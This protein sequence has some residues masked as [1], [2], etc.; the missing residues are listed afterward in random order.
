MSPNLSSRPDRILSWPFFGAG[1]A[2]LGV[3][4]QPV[5]ES[6]PSCGPDEI[7]V[8]VDALGLCAS[9]AKMVR[10]GNDYPLFFEQDFAANPGRLGH[11]AALTV[12]EVGE[13]WHDSFRP[14]QRL[15]IQPNVY[16]DGQRTIFGVNIPGAMTQYLT[17]D[18]RVLAGDSGSYV[19]PVDGDLSYAD[20]ALLE[21]WACVDVT[22]APV[23]R[24]QPKAGGLMWIKG[25]TETPSDLTMS[26]PLASQ[27]IVLSDVG[28]TLSAWVQ[29]QPVETIV[30]P[31]A[32]ASAL[33]A[34]FPQGFDDIILLHPSSAGAV[35]DALSALSPGGLLNLVTPQPLTEP[36]PTDVGRLHYDCLGIV[37]C[38]GS[39]IAQAYGYA[40]NRSDLRPGGVALIVGAGGTLGRMHIQ[41]ALEMANGPRAIIATNRGRERLQALQHDFG[42]LAEQSGC[43]LLALSPEMEPQRLATEVAR[44]TAGRGCDDVIIVAPNTQAI[45]SSLDFLAADG[46]LNIFAGMPAGTLVPL[47]LGRV[48]THAAQFT[49]TSG[50]TVADQIEVLHKVQKGTLSPARSVAAIG[51]MCALAQAMQAVLD[52]QFPGKII[53]YPQLVNL[54]LVSLKELNMR[55]PDVAAGLSP[56]GFWTPEAERILLRDYV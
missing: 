30:R 26:M 24:L 23:R 44:L 20:I 9:D 35:S 1:I 34:E 5:E 16:N 12:I 43:E 45:V 50:S 28:E 42:S 54:P 46:L 51:G 49:G 55:L 2:N 3:N 13:R 48:A 18:E 29:S 31:G 10:M 17:L 38:P 22:Y 15:G 32:D 4:G 39:D 40:R 14:G 33:R 6:M 56:E 37:G 7:L 27:K 41:R 36:V 53:I 25:E 19:F 11:E 52:H 8:R 21:P 47:P